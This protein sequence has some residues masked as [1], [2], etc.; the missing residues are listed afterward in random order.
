MNIIKKI[1]FLIAIAIMF[2][3]CE[4]VINVELNNA[5]PQIVI[6][7]VVTDRDGPYTIKISKTGNYFEPNVFPPVTGAVVVI[8]DNTGNTDSLIETTAGSYQTTKLKGVI[9][10][11]YNLTVNI[12]GKEYK[13]FSTMLSPTFIDSLTYKFNPN[14][15]PGQG[16]NGGYD[17]HCYF[18][19][20][21]EIRDYAL[22]KL[23]VNG[24]K[25]DSYF[26][27]TGKYNSSE[28]VD[29]NRFRQRFQKNDTVKIELMNI[30]PSAYDYFS[31]LNNIM[32]GEGMRG[33]VSTGTP[34]NPN[35]NISNGALGY[36][37]AY[38]VQSDSVIIK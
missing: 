23:Y 27:Y 35:T 24:K 12:D 1:F 33:I 26:L 34:A 21:P 18:K 31:T 20:K 8:S 7:G 38:S 15:G 16:K 2:N 17:L 22:L 9:G 32:A 19:D 13:S 3:S 37:T 28:F 10:N 6:E 14:T 5:A 36:F 4:E 25:D 11:T 30:E 29:Y